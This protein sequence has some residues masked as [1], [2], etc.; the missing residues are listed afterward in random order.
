MD[1]ELCN[2]AIALAAE[3]ADILGILEG[4]EPAQWT[5]PTRLPGWDVGVLVAHLVR[6]LNQV[7]TLAA[8]PVADA[9]SRT[10]VSYWRF[11]PATIAPG[12]SA[13]A[14]E[15]ARGAT[16]EKLRGALATALAETLG[17]VQ[18]LPPNTV[19]RPALGPITLQEY[20]PTRVLEV[21]VHGLDLRRA[22]DLAATPTAEALAMTV[23]ILERL[24]GSA[25]PP[26]LADPVEFIEAATGRRASADPRFPLLG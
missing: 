8:S 14:V 21:C 15:S 3:T 4:L 7:P 10:R 18:R 9:P 22:L 1:A 26:E 17:T 20:L 5:S 19:L 11:D 16:P 12:I 24:L 23:D 6:A 13:R 25:R 2:V